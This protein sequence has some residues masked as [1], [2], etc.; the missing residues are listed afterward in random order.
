M[1]GLNRAER[2]LGQGYSTRMDEL[3]IQT[4][5]TQAQALATEAAQPMPLAQ[6]VPTIQINNHRWP[7]VKRMSALAAANLNKALND[8]D[9]FG[10]V[11]GIAAMTPKQYRDQVRAYALSDLDDDHP[12]FVDMDVLLE[13]FKRGQEQLAA[14]PTN[15]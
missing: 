7:L 5:P 1:Y 6:A 10:V 3:A 13:A 8:D 9:L 12:D 4:I 2:S 15:R 14:R 11:E